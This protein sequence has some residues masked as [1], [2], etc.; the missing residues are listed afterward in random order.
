MILSDVLGHKVVD[1][2]G[3]VVGKVVD[4]RFRLEGGGTPSAARLVGLLVSPRSATS[5]MGYERKAGGPVLVARLLRWIH[6]GSFLVAWESI[7]AFHDDRVEL[8]PG[9]ERLDPSL[10]G[11]D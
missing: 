8:R 10:D 9:Y 6:R 7:A 3:T 2:E 1:S 11:A 4:A 5:F